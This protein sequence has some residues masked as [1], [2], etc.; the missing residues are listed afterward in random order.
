MLIHPRPKGRAEQ[1]GDEA[2]ASLSLPAS[3]CLPLK[4]HADA[5]R[6]LGQLL[7]AHKNHKKISEFLKKK[8]ST[9][10]SLT[11]KAKDAP[12]TLTPQSLDAWMQ[13]L[14]TIPEIAAAQAESTKTKEIHSAKATP[15]LNYFAALTKLLDTEALSKAENTQIIEIATLR[16]EPPKLKGMAKGAVFV[17]FHLKMTRE[18][19][20]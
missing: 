4:E 7:L 15:L 19:Q 12:E 8:Q 1:I 10:D 18:T 16:A 2:L 20:I 6:I 9:I 17:D 11:A 3:T 13:W 14:H 5:Y